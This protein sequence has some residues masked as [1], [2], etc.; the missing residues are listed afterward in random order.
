MPML[1]KDVAN[2]LSHRNCFG[3]DAPVCAGRAAYYT[4]AEQSHAFCSCGN[5]KNLGMA[6][7]Y[8]DELRLG[9]AGRF[10]LI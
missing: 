5:P 7:T 8:V 9:V 6:A 10:L 3:G 2:D 4:I 1:G